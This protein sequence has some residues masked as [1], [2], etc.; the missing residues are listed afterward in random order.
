[1]GLQPAASGSYSVTLV[2]GEKPYVGA[3]CY[4][5][6]SVL[7]IDAYPKP[8]FEFVG[9]IGDA[10]GSLPATQVTVTKPMSISGTLRVVNAPADA[11]VPEPR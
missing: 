1:V 5:P 7:S 8:G 2:A 9:W 6:G 3:E 4:S 11:P 10:A